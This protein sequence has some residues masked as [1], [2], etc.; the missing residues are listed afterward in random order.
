MLTPTVLLN[1]HPQMRVMKDEVFGPVVNILPYTDF[2]A[3]LDAVNDSEYGLQA[4]VFTGDLTQ[5]MQAVNVLDVGGVMINDVPTFR[6]DQM[7]YG[8]NKRSGI[9][10]EGGL[11]GL[12]PYLNLDH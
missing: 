11:H 6:V 10:R 1:S 12:I 7:P 9:G 5:S 4:G 2:T 8:G 3:A